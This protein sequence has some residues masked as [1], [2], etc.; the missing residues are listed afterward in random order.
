MR[1][2]PSIEVIARDR[3]SIYPEALANGA[4]QA[5]QVADRW[6]LCQ[7]LGTALQNLLAKHTKTLRS[8]AKELTDAKQP[9]DALREP[10]LEL[11]EPPPI[12]HTVGSEALR[13]HQFD[14]AKRLRAAGRSF[15]Q[16]AK[17]LQINRRTART[18]ATAASLPRR[19]LPQATSRVT[20]YLPALRA[21]WL[22]GYHQGTQLWHKLKAHG[23]QGSLSSIYRALKTMQLQEGQGTARIALER[24]AMRSPRQAMWL[25]IRA[26]ADLTDEERAYRDALFRHEPRIH[27]T[28][29]L[30]VR[31]QQLIRE[32]QADRFDT[33]LKDVE[34]AGIP[35]LRNFAQSLR[36]DYQPVKAA[37]SSPWS[38]GQTE[39]NVNRLKLI[40]RTM[41]GRAGFALLQRRVLYAKN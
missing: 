41:Y 36:G 1:D 19:I 7:N 33:W 14:E 3:A 35:E 29:T 25:L 34:A 9:A 17:E 15:L 30:A 24:V 18:Y 27:E 37:L 40:K 12:G 5:E 32:R 22:D 26:E 38:N 11:P 8:V 31:F 23:Y 20:P 10:L 13:Q 6:H 2:H 4:P 21:C 28:A 16:I 39:G